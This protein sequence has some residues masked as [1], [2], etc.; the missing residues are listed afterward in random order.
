[1]RARLN[2]IFSLNP[3]FSV[4]KDAELELVGRKLEQEQAEMQRLGSKYL[5]EKNALSKYG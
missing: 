3:S 2:G 1:M 4:V 5:S